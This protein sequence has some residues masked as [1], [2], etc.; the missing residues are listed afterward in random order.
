[1]QEE[2]DI[3]VISVNILD[4]PPSLRCIHFL[5]PVDIYIRLTGQNL[6]LTMK[7]AGA[8]IIGYPFHEITCLFNAPPWMPHIF[9]TP[10][11]VAV[12]PEIRNQIKNFAARHRGKMPELGRLEKIFRDQRD[13][14]LLLVQP[15][16]EE[17]CLGPAEINRIISHLRYLESG[18][19]AE[20]EKI[21]QF[22]NF[23]SALLAEYDIF[24]ADGS[25]EYHFGESQRP[26]RVCRWCGRR[27]PE[28]S[29]RKKAHAISEGLGNKRIVT[30][31]E[32]DDCNETFGNGIENSLVAYLGWGNTF[33]EIRGKH[34]IPVFKTRNLEMRNIGEREHALFFRAPAGDNAFAEN[35]EIKPL[36]AEM[37]HVI[38]LQDLYRAM[39]KFALGI[40]PDEKMAEFRETVQWVRGL[41]TFA[42][43]PK[44]ASLLSKHFFNPHPSISVLLSKNGDAN[45]PKAFAIFRYTCLVYLF[46]V[47]TSEAEAAKF[48]DAENYRRFRDFAPFFQSDQWKFSDFS[49]PN[50][51]PFRFIL[52]FQR[53][54]T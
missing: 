11:T 9:A 16:F 4:E 5:E 53:H 52:N 8:P 37:P 49:E 22:D 38:A 35:R 2:N 31:T 40:L 17:I 48:S 23:A 39:S 29:F 44:V 26:K 36:V 6:D 42:A 51:H 15:S 7:F 21:G 12:S 10:K 19:P 34:G 24:V 32:C 27:M 50:P 45:L 33:F 54:H 1:M 30:N 18:D 20:L 25:R 46:I 41:K 14:A 47:P 43:L 13:G 28:V 3:P